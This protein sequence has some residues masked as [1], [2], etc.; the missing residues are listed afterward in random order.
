MRREH[1]IQETTDEWDLIIDMPLDGNITNLTGLYTQSGSPSSWVTDP[2]D[3]TRQVACFNTKTPVIYPDYN[4]QLN[5]SV[6]ANKFKMSLDFWKINYSSGSH[7]NIIDSSYGGGWQ[8]S[9]GLGIVGQCTSRSTWA[10]GVS[11][12]HSDTYINV[13]KNLIPQH[14]WFNYFLQYYDNY[15]D[16]VITNLQTGV[17]VAEKHGSVATG[18]S[19]DLN[20]SRTKIQLGSNNQWS[21]DRGAYSYL[22]NF[23]MWLHK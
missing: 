16:I 3:S 1:N 8:T 7:P 11:S 23:K 15:I 13:S 21:D 2:S 5:Q 12:V 10:F 17:V 6:Y 19:L 22:R 20:E 9:G 14:T 18:Y 4:F